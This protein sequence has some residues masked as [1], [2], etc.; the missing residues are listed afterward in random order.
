MQNYQLF[1]RMSKRTGTGYDI[2]QLKNYSPHI[3]IIFLYLASMLDYFFEFAIEFISSSFLRIELNHFVL[4]FQI[5][6]ISGLR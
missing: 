3:L 5:T 6:L 1:L 4:I 2:S